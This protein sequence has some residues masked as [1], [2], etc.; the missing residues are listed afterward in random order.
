MERLGRRV[1]WVDVRDE[2]EMIRFFNAPIDTESVPKK[3]MKSKYAFRVTVNTDGTLKHRC[4][5]VGCGYSQ[6][7]GQDYDETFAPTAKYKSL[8]MLLHLAAVFDWEIHG[9][10]VE[11]A[12][13]ESDIDK[14]IYMTLPTDVYEDSETHKPVVVRLRRSLYGLKQAGELWYDK[15]DKIFKAEGYT[16][17]VHD[18]C[19]YIKR[20]VETGAVTIICCYVDDILFIGNSPTEIE[21]T[22]K[23]FRA[24]V[25]NLTSMDEVKRYIGVD[26]KRDRVAH[27]ISLSQVPYIEKI[28]RSNNI[29]QDLHS[30]KVSIPMSD[31][32]DF[33]TLGDGTVKP[34]QDKVGQFRFLPD[35]TRPDIATAVGILGSAAAKPTRAHLR[36]VNHLAKYLAQSKE[37]E[38]VLGGLDDNVILFGYTDA[39]HNP[40]KTS[41]PRLGYCFYLNLESGTIFARSVKD[42]CVSHSSCESEIKAIDTAIRQAIW[43]RGF[44]SE[45][46]YPQIAPTVL[47]TDSESAIK[48]GELCN[49]GNNSMH[50][51]M[52]I[53]YIHECIEAGIIK[54]T[55]VNTD[56]EVAD[57]LTKLLPITSH[58]LHREFLLHGHQGLKPSGDTSKKNEQKRNKR[59][60][61]KLNQF[62]GKYVYNKQA[63]R[64]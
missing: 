31:T 41:R 57:V 42:T 30:E 19:I 27:T 29:S 13:L 52:R 59:I 8:C 6:V 15:I 48:L 32:A 5:L 55:Y 40:D 58:N 49:I 12:F 7:L 11:Q 62:T 21:S 43:M 51:V 16:R 44:L 10:D 38:L 39:S 3:P 17:L 56:N 34:I 28:M 47:H 22:I 4:R 2:D 1:T 64:K 14:E 53:N 37:L 23:H 33:A 60:L 20:D 45:L 61:F 18:Q 36:G 25:T 46:G 35:R 24:Q 9:L 50:I 26:I 63:F 54:L